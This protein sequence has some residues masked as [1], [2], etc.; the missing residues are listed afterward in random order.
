MPVIVIS[1]SNINLV[2]TCFHRLFHTTQIWV[3]LL[4]I[5][6]AVRKICFHQS[7]SLPAGVLWGSFVTQPQR[8]SAGRLPIRGITQILVVTHHQYGISRLLPQISFHGEISVG[9]FLRLQVC[10]LHVLP[11]LEWDGLHS[12]VFSPFYIF[13]CQGGG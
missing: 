11:S 13:F 10:L 4:L 8:T 5:G 6:H 1:L 9:F 7:D 3:V 2:N 12:I